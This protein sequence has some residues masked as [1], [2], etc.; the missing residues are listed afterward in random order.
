[1]STHRQRR[2]ELVIRMQ[3]RRISFAPNPLRRKEDRL[4]AALLLGALVAALLVIPAAAVLATTVRDNSA[5]A[6]ARQRAVLRPAQARTLDGTADAQLG[7]STTPVR[8]QWFDAAGTARE[9]RH[10]VPIGTAVGTELQIWLDRTGQLARA[11][12]TPA[13]SAALGG[14]AGVTASTLAWLFLFAS[15][16][17][18]RR[19][20]DRRR[21]QAWEREWEQIAPRWTRRQP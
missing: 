16:R 13:G 18:C 5:S 10:D 15:Y 4:E 8:V 2:A 9:G 20:L 12:R 14:V 19:P 1:M 21:T 6:A 7:Q 11:P 3:L 17:L